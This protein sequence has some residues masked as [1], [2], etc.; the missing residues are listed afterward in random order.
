MLG[1]WLIFPYIEWIECVFQIAPMHDRRCYGSVGVL[2][3]KIYAMGG[4]N[5]TRR[6][7]SCEYYNPDTNQW[8]LFANMNR[9]RSDADACTFNGR[10]YVT[11]FVS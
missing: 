8:T 1:K 3:G 11:G 6:L 10:I 5:G 4:N 7:Y 9:R 2:N